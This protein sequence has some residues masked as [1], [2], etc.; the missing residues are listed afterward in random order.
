MKKHTPSPGYTTISAHPPGVSVAVSRGVMLSAELIMFNISLYF[1]MHQ[2]T[3]SHNTLHLHR[4][5]YLCNHT[6]TA[7]LEEA[8]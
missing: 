3:F 7:L 1:P 2:E 4:K 6:S 5:V 8:L